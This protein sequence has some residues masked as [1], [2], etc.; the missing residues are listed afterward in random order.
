MQYKDYYQIM[1][2]HP[3]ASAKDIKVAYQKLAHAYH[4]DVSKAPNAEER[5]KEL[6]EAYKVLKNSKKRAAY[7]KLLE[8]QYVDLQA[9]QEFKPPPANLY[10]KEP[11][12][13][14]IFSILLILCVLTYLFWPFS[15]TIAFVIFIMYL[16]YQF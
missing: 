11:S 5:F 9:Q 1:G 6:S 15:V 3:D 2:L 4:P 7:D 13:A 12:I 10:V 16:F 14:L 8:N